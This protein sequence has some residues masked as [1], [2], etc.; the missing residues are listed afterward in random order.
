MLLLSLLYFSCKDNLN[1]PICQTNSCFFSFPHKNR[2][3]G[4]APPHAKP[5]PLSSSFTR[6]PSGLVPKR[7]PRVWL[8]SAAPRVWRQSTVA[9][10]FTLGPDPSGALD[11]TLGPD[12]SEQF[13][14]HSSARRPSHPNLH[15]SA[16][17]P[18]HRRRWS[19]HPWQ[20]QSQP[21]SCQSS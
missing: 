17:H 21:W 13:K 19:T 4:Q 14:A 10:D 3:G 2:V 8:Q 7:S 5:A 9:C 20:Q 18:K 1:F 11:F 15:Q 6:R 16:S 12:P